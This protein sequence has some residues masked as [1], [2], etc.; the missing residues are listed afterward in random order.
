MAKKN[1]Q[2][3]KALAARG[4]AGTSQKSST[5]SDTTS[6]SIGCILPNFLYLAPVSETGNVN[7][8]QQMGITHIISIGKNPVTRE[9][10]ITYHKFGMLDNDQADLRA[11]VDKVCEVLNVIFPPKQRRTDDQPEGVE[12]DSD[13]GQVDF[14]ELFEANLD[15]SSAKDEPRVE[16]NAKVLI[17]C[18]AAIS[19]SPAVIAGYLMKS[20]GMTLRESFEVLVRARDAVSPNIGFLRQLCEREREIFGLADGEKGTVDFE[21]LTSN[22]KLAKMLDIS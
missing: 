9:D 8:L 18:S 21:K 11:A 1:K 17:H 2:K 5:P 16:G 20:Q 22:V 10:G 6:S 13:E 19:R 14:E 4:A 12:G 3:G 15:A 7:L